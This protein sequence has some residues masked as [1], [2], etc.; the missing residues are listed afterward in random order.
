MSRASTHA[1]G[2]LA[3]FQQA[4]VSFRQPIRARTELVS[5]HWRF[6]LDF[7][8]LSNSPELE[9]ALFLLFFS[10]DSRPAISRIR[11][12]RFEV[13]APS[14]TSP[15]Q[16]LQIDKR[17]QNQILARAPLFPKFVLEGAGMYHELR[18]R[19][20]SVAFRQ[21]NRDPPA[22]VSVL[23]YWRFSLDFGP[24]STGPNFFAASVSSC[25]RAD[26]RA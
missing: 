19:R 6:S 26:P 2:Q 11:C 10:S 16:E 3:P 25:A 15:F 8:A 7:G 17:H 13:P 4:S 9:S 1:W 14:A 23:R 20:T 22:L 21:P 24:A 12:R 5:P 18:K